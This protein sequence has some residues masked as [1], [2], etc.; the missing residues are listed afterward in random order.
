MYPRPIEVR[1]LEGYRLAITFEDGVHAELDFT[2][3]TRWN[4]IYEQLRQLDIFQCVRI[5]PEAESLV[6]PNG[7]DVCPDVLYHLATGA[8][9]PGE[10]P[11]Q[12]AILVRLHRSLARSGT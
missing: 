2:P 5:D 11:R 9:L 3:M 4:G 7:V 10:L 12:A 1:Y 8:T 6:W